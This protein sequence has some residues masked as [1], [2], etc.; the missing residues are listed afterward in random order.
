M[1]A[2]KIVM[3]TNIPLNLKN[4]SIAHSMSEKI[5]MKKLIYLPWSQA[6]GIHKYMNLGAGLSMNPLALRLITPTCVSPLAEGIWSL[7]EEE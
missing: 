2:K 5:S 3:K 6:H 7:D 4:F 1:F